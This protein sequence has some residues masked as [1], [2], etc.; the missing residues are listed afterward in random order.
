MI[1]RTTEGGSQSPGYLRVRGQGP[2]SIAHGIENCSIRSGMVPITGK[3]GCVPARPAG[4]RLTFVNRALRS[5]APISTMVAGPSAS[6]SAVFG[7]NVTL[8]VTVAGEGLTFQWRKDGADFVSATNATF[9][10]TA[11]LQALDEANRPSWVGRRCT[12]SFLTSINTRC[13]VLS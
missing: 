9:S 4:S 10:P 8:V 13:R 1:G 3:I 6:D 11:H 7:S 5:A 12:H 2:V